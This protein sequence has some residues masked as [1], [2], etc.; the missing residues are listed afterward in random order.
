MIYFLFLLNSVVS[1]WF[2]A[3]YQVL[4]IADQQEYVVNNI[5]NSVYVVTVIL[6]ILLIYLFRNY[7]MYLFVMILGTGI[8][9]M[10]VVYF[11]KKDYS[12]VLEEKD[13]AVLEK[14]EL[15]SLKKNIFALAVSKFATVINTSSDNIVISV[16]IGTVVVGRYSN[17]SYIVSAVSAVIAIIFNGLLASI[18]NANVLEVSDKMQIL[19]YRISFLNSCIYG[20]CYICFMQLIQNFIQ[21]WAGNEYLLDKK[22][23][24][25][26]GLLFLIPGLHHTCMIFKDA[27]GLFWETRYRML[28]TTFINILLSII[29]APVLGLSG[30][31]MATIIAYLLTTFIYDPYLIT[32]KVF[33][34]SAK[35]FYNY[36]IKSFLTAVLANFLIS[37]PLGILQ[38][39]GWSQFIGKAFLTVIM[40]SIIYLVVSYR[41]SEF[42]YYKD[43]LKKL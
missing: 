35:G 4:Y 22:T 29:L 21:L 2:G 5:K 19:F 15:N 3:Y 9:N 23:V 1:Y 34:S 27:C 24:Y 38:V 8:T 11:A 32:K 36:Y 30:I 16:M 41:S 26:I 33:R 28:A 14:N 13:R 12:A 39:N 7:Y 43:L 10:I 40:S 31:F 17:Y 42:L 20:I 6:Q 18:G 25:V 37:F